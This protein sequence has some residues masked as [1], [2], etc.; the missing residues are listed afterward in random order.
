MAQTSQ[1]SAL[2][3]NA[4]FRPL[5]YFPLSVIGWQDAVQAVIAGKVSVVAEHAA[6]VRS[7]SRVLQMPAVV[8]LR[9]YQR[10]S[11]QVPFTRFNLFLRDGFRC[12]YCGRGFAS[13]DLTFDH[14]VPRAAG[15]VTS[16]EN[17]V[18]A[19]GPCNGAKGHQRKMTPLIAPRAPAP[20]HLIKARR[21]LPNGYLHE[22]WHDYLYWDAVLET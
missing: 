3:L 14:V 22:S 9:R 4:D 5:S 11:R 16:W 20:E 7:P 6:L 1:H 8:A 2:L 15:G 12:Q 13:H 18:A 19:C 21:A 10:R 17:V